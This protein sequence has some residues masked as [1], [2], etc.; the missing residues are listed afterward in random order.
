MSLPLCYHR[1]S[2]AVFSA[3]QQHARQ[4]EGIHPSSEEHPGKML[5]PPDPGRPLRGME[6]QSNWFSVLG[7]FKNSASAGIPKIS[8]KALNALSQVVNF[9]IKSA[10]RSSCIRL[11]IYCR[12]LCR[13]GVALSSSHSRRIRARNFGQ[14]LITH[15]R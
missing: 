4:R 14:G 9:I 11:R 2:S 3:A 12:K 13:V 15:H 7:N 8:H 5:C 1:H 6:V 10:P